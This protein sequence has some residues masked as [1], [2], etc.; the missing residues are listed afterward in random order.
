MS[1]LKFT[2]VIILKITQRNYR[3]TNIMQTSR[4][5]ESEGAVKVRNAWISSK[6]PLLGNRKTNSLQHHVCLTD[7][8]D[9]LR[10][11]LLEYEAENVKLGN[12][13]CVVRPTVTLRRNDGFLHSFYNF[14]KSNAFG[15][16]FIRTKFILHKI[17]FQMSIL[18][19]RKTLRMFFNL[20][21]KNFEKSFMGGHDHFEGKGVSGNKNKYK[22]FC[23]K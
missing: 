9:G 18:L 19:S 11:S 21:W 3:Q 13:A 17:F 2:E 8:L 15:E 6:K 22:L 12:C 5:F 4:D 23:K 1:Y 14:L 16:N 10:Q 20:C 7:N